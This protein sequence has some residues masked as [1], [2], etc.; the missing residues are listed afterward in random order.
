M[1]RTRWIAVAALATITLLGVA[2][3]G[4]E[5]STQATPTSA[6]T[7]AAAAPKA[8]TSASTAAA[9]AAPPLTTPGADGTVKAVITGFKLPTLAVKTGTV[10]EFSNQDTTA[11]TATSDDGKTINSGSLAQNGAPYKF[12]ASTAGTFPYA[13]QIHPSMTA[14]ITVQ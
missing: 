2:C 8:A 7:A 10:V 5:T 1:H 4:D 9:T 6:T 11:H 12:T 3:S 14:T 13:C